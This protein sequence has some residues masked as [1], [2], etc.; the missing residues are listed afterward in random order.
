MRQ[1][2]IDQVVTMAKS[3]FGGFD[4]V[5]RLARAYSHAVVLK[6]SQRIAEV[7]D[8][9]VKFESSIAS[10]N[11]PGTWGFSFDIL[12]SGSTQQISDEQERQMSVRC[13]PD[14]TAFVDPSL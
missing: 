13:E 2:A 6:D 11:F 3:Q 4:L 8:A 7:R 10:D 12:V 5:S 1:I 14:S 9:I